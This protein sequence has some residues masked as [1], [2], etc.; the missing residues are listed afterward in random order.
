[1]MILVTGGSGSG[2]SAFAEQR[3]LS[4][5][6]GKRT[7]IATMQ[8]FDEEGRR[9]VE[10]HRAMRAGKGFETV[11]RYTGLKDLSLPSGGT[12]L[13]ECMS[14]LVANEM[15]GEDGAGADTVKEVLEGV[16]RI[17]D[18]LS[19]LVIVTNEIFSEAVPYGGDTDTYRMYLGEINQQLAG[20]ADEVCEVVYG[21]P[22]YV[23]G[24]ER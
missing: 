3:V 16:R 9:R 10:R 12:A 18:Q 20:M 15:F 22:V 13:L 5:G 7:Y 17:R 21:I 19:H 1:M 6:E 11:E 23:K 4:L 2:K 8:P 24:G 14:N